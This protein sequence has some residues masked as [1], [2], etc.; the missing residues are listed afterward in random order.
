MS[1]PRVAVVILNW[2]GQQLLEKF[3]PSVLQSTYSNLEIIVADNGSTDQSIE[4]LET[5]FASVRR[6]ILSTNSGYAGGYNKALKQVDADYY[7]LLNSDVEVSP[8]WIEPVIDLMENDRCIAAC[9]P[10]ILSY[11]NTDVF[12]YAGA[13]GGWMDTLGYPFSRGR[14]FDVCEKDHQQYDTAIPIFWATGACM[15]IRSELF[16]KMQIGRAHV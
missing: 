11:T 15:M 4:L 13:A 12:E 2:N 14:V 9:Q 3:L 16:H 6:I 8:N 10:K 5:K 1:A 7:V